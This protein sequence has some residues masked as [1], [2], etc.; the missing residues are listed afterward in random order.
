MR[1][2]TQWRSSRIK[3][4]LVSAPLSKGW[5][6][7]VDL[8]GRLTLWHVHCGQVLQPEFPSRR[9]CP[10]CSAEVPSEVLEFFRDGEKKSRLIKFAKLKKFTD[11]IM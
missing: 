1:Y 10:W 4:L 5:D 2:K 11:S 3:K 8:D 6:V 9:I 7:E